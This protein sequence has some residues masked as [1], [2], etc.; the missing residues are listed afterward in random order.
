MLE[1][2]LRKLGEILLCYQISDPPLTCNFSI[3]GE[4]VEYNNLFHDSFDGFIR[5]GDKC[6]IILPPTIKSGGEI[7]V[8]ASVLHVDYELTG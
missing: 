1:E 3:I 7:L 8:K 6:F 4:Q 2:F 5:Q